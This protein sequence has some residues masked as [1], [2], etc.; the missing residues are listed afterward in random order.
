MPVQ[1]IDNDA[2]FQLSFNDAGS[3]LVVIDFFATWCGPCHAIAPVFEE[4]SNQYEGVVF[5]K[6]DVDKCFETKTIYGVR[7]MPTFL[8]IRNETTLHKIQG[9][10]AEELRNKVHEL[11]LDSSANGSSS[12]S[13]VGIPGMVDLLSQVNISQLTC[14]NESDDHTVKYIFEENSD[15]YLESDCDPELLISVEFNQNIKLHSLKLVAPH[16]FGPKTL[17]LFINQPH[18]MDFDSAR[19]GKPIQEFSLTKDDI[20]ENGLINLRFVKFQNV[21]NLTI[22]IPD[23]QGDEETTKIEKLTLIGKTVATTNMSEFKRVAGK[24]GESH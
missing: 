7:A 13:S 5:L 24:E 4:L 19:D 20:S 14:L 9:A 23:N 17:R 18:N 3:S 10:K 11:S 12:E 16:D 8:F 6:V 2:A 22:F 15:L 21:H 1:H